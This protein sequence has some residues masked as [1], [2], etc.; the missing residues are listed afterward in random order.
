MSDDRWIRLRALFDEIQE[1]PEAERTSFLDR[2]LTGEPELRAELAVLLADVGSTAR[3]LAEPS[4]AAAGSMVGPYRLVERLGEGGFGVVYLAEQERPLRRRVAL[5]LIKPGMDSKQVVARFDAERQA[6]ALMDH[7]GI[8]QVFDAGETET[9][10]PYFAMEYVPGLPITKYC[11]EHRLAVRE[12]LALLVEVCDAVQHAHQKGVIHRDI[13]PSNVVV[14]RREGAAAPKVIDFGIAKATTSLGS[15]DTVMTHAG[16]IVGTL[17]YMSPEQAGATAAAMDTRSDIYS[18][19]VLL[20]E[21][22]I[23]ELPFDSGRLREGALS[24]VL[25]VIREE[26]PPPLTVR[27]A[28]SGEVVARV[29]ERRSTDAR[30]LLRDLRGELEWITHRALEKD[31]EHRYPSAAELA[32]DIRRYLADEPVL[33]GAPTTAYKI[34]KFV[35][36][37]RVVV[38]AA[39]VVLLSI[40]A[41]GIAAAVGF[42]RAVRSEQ[43]AVRAEQAARRE[44]ESSQRVADFLIEL[45]GA[46]SPDRSKGETLTARM[47]LDEG[48]R[49][50]ESGLKADPQ[51]RS[52]LLGTMGASYLN[53]AAFDEGV[54]LHREALA[55]AEAAEPPDATGIGRSLLGLAVGFNMSGQQDSIPAVIDRAISLL[56]GTEGADPTLL[57]RCIY[58]KG[59]WWN[60]K[61]DAAAADSL[62]SVA[63]RMEESTPSPEP[64]VLL[65]MVSTKA[66][67][68]HRRFDLDAAERDYLRVVQLAEE[69]GRPSWAV[70]AHSRLAAVYASLQES[71]KALHHAQAGLDLARRIYAPDH[72]NV[73]DA[74]SGLAAAL[75][76]QGSL[77]EA[78]AAR[79]E[80][81]GILRKRALPEAVA[82]ELN[83]LA[84]LCSALGRHEL[85]VAR[86]GEASELR[87]GTHGT[88]HTRTAES[89]ATLGACCVAAGQPE[90]ADAPFREAIAI[91][92][93]L[94]DKSIFPPV[95]WVEYADLCRDRGL[96]ERAESLYTRAEAALDSTNAGMRQH[97]GVC[98]AGHGELRSLQGR[99]DEAESMMRSGYPLI[100]GETSDDDAI[101]G[102]V[103]LSWAVVRM[104][105]GNAEG[106]LEELRR[107][108]ACGVTSEDVAGHPELAALR[109]RVDY[110]RDSFP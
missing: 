45:F 15:G 24:D 92:D 73:A 49:R 64:A 50:I 62:V 95:T 2:E 108:A 8:A 26:D 5:K 20:Y 86:A 56:G 109:S 52:R 12:R 34:R 36:R 110:P 31:P 87:R 40:V 79:E 98:L 28:R 18:L 82:Y 77:D 106:A 48:T 61:G 46:P 99:H 6:L 55:A 63:L 33:A 13:K 83:I 72:P 35:R 7:P 57:A 17:D 65:P 67:I 59:Q 19:G 23:G 58:Q 29:A 78:I 43:V 21:L 76:G 27:L 75:T 74:L 102:D 68:A 69:A 105:A 14:A 1:L 41:G 11:D 66:N 10:H 71:E 37:H 39:A 22:L 81:L 97:V 93:R 80:A 88:D 107:A 103:H 70:S 51:V 100:R 38:T 4:D 91:F 85:A 44:A 94:G 9:G 25:R 30:R 32:A 90:Q 16:M 47:L 104:R 101:L 60:A 53:L 84:R 42:S 96:F 89:L 3:F 54:R